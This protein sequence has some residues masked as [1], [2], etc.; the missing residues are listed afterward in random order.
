MELNVKLT[1]DELMNVVDAA[2]EAARERDY[3]IDEEELIKDMT[4]IIDAALSAMGIE[5]VP[6]DEDEEDEDEEEI[7]PIEEMV[8][9]LEG[10]RVI[11]KDNA[12]MLLCMMTDVVK[13]DNRIPAEVKSEF[14]QLLFIKFCAD[15][16][17][18][19]VDNR[20]E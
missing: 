7:D 10:K 20:D 5:I 1:A 2:V 13:H 4:Y 11:S 15:K 8:Y 19:G 16:D 6:A 3:M 14:A 12:R 18:W 9:V 17:I